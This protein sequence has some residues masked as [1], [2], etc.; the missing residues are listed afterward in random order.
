M[1]LFVVLLFA[2]AGFGFWGV[3]VSERYMAI[4][5]TITYILLFAAV[6]VGILWGT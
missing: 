5:D 6:F 3:F 1:S 4:V 2:M